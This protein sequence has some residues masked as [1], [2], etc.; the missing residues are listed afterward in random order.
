MY[1]STYLALKQAQEERD[2][3]Q[4]YAR[5][6]AEATKGREE[7]RNAYLKELNEK[8]PNVRETTLANPFTKFLFCY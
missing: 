7:L 2:A 3:A 5:Q 1:A 8:D 4:H 6:D